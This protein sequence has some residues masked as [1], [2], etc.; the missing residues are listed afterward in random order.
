MD[1]TNSFISFFQ[2][3]DL[4]D[5]ELPFLEALYDGNINASELAQNVSLQMKSM[6]KRVMSYFSRPEPVSKLDLEIAQENDPQIKA[7]LESTRI[8]LELARKALKDNK[9]LTPE[10]RRT[11]KEVVRSFT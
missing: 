1:S 3:R 9:G 11:L 8:K 6:G 4:N 2:S 10:Q 7:I 5:N